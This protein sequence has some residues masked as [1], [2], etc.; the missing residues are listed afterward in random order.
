MSQ[1]DRRTGLKHLR[2]RGLKAFRFA[3]TLKATAINI[4]R[5]A[6]CRK[7]RKMA[8][9]PVS[10]PFAGIFDLFRIV[11]NCYVAHPIGQNCQQ[12]RADLGLL[13]IFRLNLRQGFLRDHQL[14]SF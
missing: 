5:A 7:R 9:D 13:G 1:L 8:K 14:C 10:A 4:L 6:A 2:V 11:K 12:P 3:A